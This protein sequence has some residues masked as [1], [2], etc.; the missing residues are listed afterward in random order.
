MHCTGLTYTTWIVPSGTDRSRITLS[1]LSMRR[2]PL[3]SLH[4]LQ[5]D[6]CQV[7]CWSPL[8]AWRP[9]KETTPLNKAECHIACHNHM[10]RRG[11]VP[12]APTT[13]RSSHPSPHTSRPKR[14]DVDSSNMTQSSS[15]VLLNTRSNTR[16]SYTQPSI[17]V[18]DALHWPTPTG[19]PQV[20]SQFDTRRQ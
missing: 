12:Q 1:Q 4:S 8:Q 5:P 20:C 15:L 10:H 2:Q 18:S 17:D 7:V 13:K 16:L 6:Q 19:P 11:L 9:A 3:A 14:N